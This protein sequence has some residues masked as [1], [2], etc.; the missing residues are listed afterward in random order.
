MKYAEW[1]KI[2][3]TLENHVQSQA[4]NNVQREIECWLWIWPWITSLKLFEGQFLFLKEHINL[5]DI[6]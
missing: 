3:A 6:K 1:G 4:P 2:M 5:G